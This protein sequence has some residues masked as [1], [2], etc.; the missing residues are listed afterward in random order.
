MAVQDAVDQSYLCAE[1]LNDPSVKLSCR[2]GRSVQLHAP[3]STIFPI[4]TVVDHYPALAFQ[5]RH[6]L[7]VKSTK[8]IVPPLVADV[9]TLDTVTEMLT[10]PLRLLSYLFFRARYTRR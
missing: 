8:Q 7:K 2:D 4:T 3:P 10:S 5:A 6:F 1:L 9:F